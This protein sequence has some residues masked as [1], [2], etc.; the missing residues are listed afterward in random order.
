MLVT[1]KEGHP[2]ISSDTHTQ[3][4]TIL[5]LFLQ[6]KPIPFIIREDRNAFSSRVGYLSDY[7]S[8]TKM[9]YNISTLLILVVGLSIYE[10]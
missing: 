9:A 5:S 4:E 10:A 3:Q 8:V 2:N 6:W 1:W 7:F